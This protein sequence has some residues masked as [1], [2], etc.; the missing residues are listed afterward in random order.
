MSNYPQTAMATITAIREEDELEGVLLPVATPLGVSAGCRGAAAAVPLYTF[1]YD[2]AITSELQQEM[3]QVAYS[4]P[5]TASKSAVVDDSRT[6]VKQAEQIALVSQEEENEAIRR[7]NR[8]IYA[9]A[10]HTERGV[11]E[12][13]QLAHQRDFEGLEVKE[14]PPSAAKN[15][16]GQKEKKKQE[17]DENNRGN[18]KPKGYSA[19]GY[20]VSE[21]RFGSDYEVSEYKVSEYK[22]VYD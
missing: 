13:N 18:M 15:L 8:N 21:Y 22:S 2:T 4:I 20:E 10:Y 7:A 12:A 1:D 11:E 19:G 9:K 5:T 6:R 3:E 14:D 17:Q 16:R